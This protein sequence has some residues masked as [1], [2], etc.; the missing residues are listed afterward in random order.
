MKL[1]EYCSDCF[2]HQILCA[3]SDSTEDLAL[4][5]FVYWAKH[6]YSISVETAHRELEIAPKFET[7]L[8][9]LSGN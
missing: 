4:V 3:F 8:H 7:H 1:P 6:S 2:N 9:D 5:H